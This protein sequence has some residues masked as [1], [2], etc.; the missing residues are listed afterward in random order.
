M[1]T[2]ILTWC[3]NIALPLAVLSLVALAVTASAQPKPSTPTIETITS[4]MAQANTGNQARF[5]P[6]LPTQCGFLG[7]ISAMDVHK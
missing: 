4:R 5:R 1:V 6:Y 3:L 7:P 2:N